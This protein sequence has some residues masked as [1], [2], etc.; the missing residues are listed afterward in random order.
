MVVR[1][2]AIPGICCEIFRGHKSLVRL[3]GSHRAFSEFL[4]DDL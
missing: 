1:E 4:A 3:V 2:F